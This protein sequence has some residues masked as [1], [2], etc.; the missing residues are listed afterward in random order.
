MLD[1]KFN[2]A[3]YT[4]YVKIAKAIMRVLEQRILKAFLF[5]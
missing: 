4:A 3:Q 2:I 5:I 1:N